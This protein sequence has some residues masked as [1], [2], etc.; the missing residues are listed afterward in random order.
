MNDSQIEEELEY[1]AGVFSVKGRLIWNEKN[2]VYGIVIQTRDE[3]RI[4]TLKKILANL[5]GK[6]GSSKS[7]GYTKLFVYGKKAASK[8]KKMRE[9]CMKDMT[10]YFL[11]GMFDFGSTISLRVRENKRKKQRC[12]R[13]RLSKKDPNLLH[14]VRLGLLKYGIVSHIY[15]NGSTYTLEIDGKNN[16]QTFFEKI[17]SEL[18]SRNRLANLALN[19]FEYAITRLKDSS[20]IGTVEEE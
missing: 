5:F 16:F 13:I 1:L 12:W 17:G 15:K 10:L 6:V 8:V 18:D 20:H 14:I 9:V 11:R 19:N 2:H 7:N 4:E 3:E